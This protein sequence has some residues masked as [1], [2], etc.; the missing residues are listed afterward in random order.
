MFNNTMLRERDALSGVPPTQQVGRPSGWWIRHR[1]A[2]EDLFNE[3]PIAALMRALG[4]YETA[5][6][7]TH[8]HA[9]AHDY[10]LGRSWL[11]MWFEVRRL[12]MG[13]ELAQLDRELIQL[14]L[15]DLAYSAGFED[16]ELQ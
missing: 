6:W 4:R 7:N 2:F 8:V 9:I 3:S 11:T 13:G 5:H 10:V 1:D 14:M 12:A 15:R 16:K